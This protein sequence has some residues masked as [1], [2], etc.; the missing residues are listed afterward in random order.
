MKR[1]WKKPL[2]PNDEGKISMQKINRARRARKKPKESEEA[3]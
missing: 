2:K 3:R 1:G